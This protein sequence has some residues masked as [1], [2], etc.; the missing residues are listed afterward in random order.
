[1]PGWQN[2][3]EIGNSLASTVNGL[4][5]N[6]KALP[7]ICYGIKNSH[8]PLFFKS[9]IDHFQ[10]KGLEQSIVARDY[11]EVLPLLDQLGLPYKSIGIHYGRSRLAK[12]I[13]LIVND[14]LIAL[15][16][17]GFDV[18]LSH[19]NTYMIHAT[20]LRGKKAVTF[21][22]NDISFNLRMYNRFVDYLIT[23]SAI[24]KEKLLARGC[25]PESLIQYDGFK[26]DVYIADYVP[27]RTFLDGLP[28]REFVTVR[29]ESI[30]AHYIPNG[31]VS[32][33]PTLLRRFE[34]LGINVLFLPRYKSDRA[35]ADGLENVCIP[36][37]PLN[38]LDVCYHSM[39]VL[40]GA[41]TFAREAAILGTPAVSFFPRPDLLSVDRK[42][43][44]M[45]WML[46]SRD[47]ERITDYVLSSGPRKTGRER[48]KSVQQE[49][50][51]ILEKI[52]KI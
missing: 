24:P 17:P 48:S 33:V 32:L 8:E 23:P 5:L 34:Q 41:G 6:A 27:D 10:K 30:E 49:V 16:A 3:S 46:H 36:P 2:Q 12:L 28:F 35:Y 13:G 44:Q 43:V 31:T 39:A 22:D 47:T 51:A 15:K 42:M 4:D 45:G 1:M 7:R 40:T 18:S 21:T 11:I 19:G 25:K 37:K 52:L 9:I 20:K 38:G 50:F 14:S 29:P 26:E